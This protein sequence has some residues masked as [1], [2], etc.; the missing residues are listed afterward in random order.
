[1]PGQST[2]TSVHS[3]RVPTGA[4]HEARERALS[5]GTTISQVAG[6]MIQLYAQ[7]RI[8]PRVS[9]DYDAEED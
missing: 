6:L 4:W 2:K 1:M 9:V 7:G 3:V 5:E 8:T